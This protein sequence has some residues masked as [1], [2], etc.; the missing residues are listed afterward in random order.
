MNCISKCH[1][2]ITKI[3]CTQCFWH[4]DAK[5]FFLFELSVLNKGNNAALLSKLPDFYFNFQ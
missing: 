3:E 1:P 5:G 4:T 2:Y